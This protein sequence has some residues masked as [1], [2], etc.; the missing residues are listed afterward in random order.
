M[1]LAL[2]LAV[3]TAVVVPLLPLMI[4]PYDEGLI[5]Y[6]AEQ[7]LRGRQPAVHF[8]SPYGPGVFYLIAAAFRLF[9]TR[10][11]VERWVSGGLLVAIGALGYTLLVDRPGIWLNPRA[12]GHPSAPDGRRLAPLVIASIAALAVVLMLACGWWYTPVNGGT[13]ALLLL[14]GVALQRGLC[15]G[16][17][18]WAAV[19][20][21][22]AGVALVWRLVFGGALMI[23]NLLSWALLAG[24]ARRSDRERGRILG[25]LAMT[26]AAAVVAA[27]VYA[28]LV[29]AGGQRAF[30]SLFVWPITST[31]A[32]DLPWP[33]FGIPPPK[34]DLSPLSRLASSTNGAAF[35]YGVVALLLLL[36]RLSLRPLPRRDQCLGV[37]LLLL[38]PSLFLYAQGRTDYLH[39]TPLLTFSLLLAALVATSLQATVDRR[40]EATPA[41]ASA[42]PRLS[43]LGADGVPRLISSA[44]I[45]GVWAGLGITLWSASLLL[46]LPTIGFSLVGIW[47]SA[48]RTPLPLPG[49]RGAG[50]YP[51]YRYSRQY[52]RLVPLIQYHVA[53]AQTIFSGTMR[54]DI[55]LTNDVLIYFLAERDAATYYWCLDAGVTSSAPVQQEMLTEMARGGVAAAVIWTAPKAGEK[56]E[57]GLSSGVHLLDDWLDREFQPM[58]IRGVLYDLRIRKGLWREE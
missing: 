10:L 32:A 56:N 19:A 29:T 45:R 58:P 24:E 50:V 37:W 23:A 38:L 12:G 51:P 1:L 27:P 15:R 44:T 22:L 47:R 7:V 8:Y 55:Y 41:D 6:G 4:N 9:G 18:G 16:S 40:T 30:Q 35:Y 46:L 26:A 52:Q 2:L 13:V 28:A 21:A 49:A 11:L 31:H 57:G 42:E 3:S 54:H 17:V 25:L 48:G 34:T 43:G 36:W 14:S 53:P 5:A 39:I 33:R 20:G